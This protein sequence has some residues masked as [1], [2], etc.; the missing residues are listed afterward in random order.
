MIDPKVVETP[1]VVGPDGR[2]ITG[3]EKPRFE[4][5]SLGTWRITM[6]NAGVSAMQL[7]TMPNDKVVWFDTTFLGPSALQWTPP[8]TCPPNFE[9]NL[10]DC[11]VH[12]LEYDGLHDTTRPLTV[13]TYQFIV[14]V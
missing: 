3:P 10:P 7:Q 2:P 13:C 5:T 4:S 11:F 6:P 12:S 1:A 9:T 14:C 8:G